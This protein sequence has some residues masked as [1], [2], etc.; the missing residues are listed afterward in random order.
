M[1]LYKKDKEG[2]IGKLT[3]ALDKGRWVGCWGLKRVGKHKE[4]T[5]AKV[6]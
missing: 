6:G 2:I 3:Q 4:G 1:H 5:G